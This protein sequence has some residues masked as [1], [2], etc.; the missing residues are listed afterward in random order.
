LQYEP[1]SKKMNIEKITKTYKDEWVLVEVLKEDKEGN[2]L[3]V[4]LITHS[5]NRD[6]TYDKLKDAKG[7]DIYHFYTGEYPKKGFA[8]AF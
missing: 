6:D 2:P 4:K 8:I 7:K 5:K 1:K 3:D